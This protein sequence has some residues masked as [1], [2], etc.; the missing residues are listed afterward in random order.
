MREYALTYGGPPD[1]GMPWKLFLAL[2]QGV[3]QAEARVRLRLLDGVGL[4]ISGAFGDKSAE[5][6]RRSL[7]DIAH[8][9]PKP[10]REEV[11]NLWGSDGA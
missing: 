11:V 3:G 2:L 10:H 5:E 7:Y 9:G 8:P 1:L 6:R 4:A